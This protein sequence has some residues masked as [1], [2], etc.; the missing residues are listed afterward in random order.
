MKT[1]WEWFKE[2]VLPDFIK[3]FVEEL[4]RRVV[5]SDNVKTSG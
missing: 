1:I 3:V 4:Y 5:K 2:H